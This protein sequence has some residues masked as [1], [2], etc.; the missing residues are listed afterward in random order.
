MR[1]LQI[2]IIL[3]ILLILT[4]AMHMLPSVKSTQLSNMLMNKQISYDFYVSNQINSNYYSIP[5]F[6]L[7][8]LNV[9]FTYFNSKK[10]NNGR[11]LMKEIVIPETNLDDDE[12]ESEI[13]GKS[14]KAAF[15]VVIVFSFVI[16]SLFP[17]A[18]S[19]F[20]ELAAYSVFAVAA[21]P[22]IGLITY[23]ITY[24]VLYSR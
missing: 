21:L 8:L 6:I 5:F 15:S 16:L 23:F 1:N 20:N 4:F 18:I 2:T 10:R 3:R 14:A 11:I 19:F 7:V 12:R 17:M 22:I 24:K 13:T 9:W